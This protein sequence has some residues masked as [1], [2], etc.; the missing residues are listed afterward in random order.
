MSTIDP[1]RY[2]LFD[3]MAGGLFQG[4][5]KVFSSEERLG[6]FLIEFFRDDELEPLLAEL[7][8]IAAMEMSDQDWETYWWRS[9][10]QSVPRDAKASHRLLE[11]VM[12]AIST[13]ISGR[14]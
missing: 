2:K 8:D 3:R 9:P 4:T 10:A 6:V 12:G 5:A 11:A 14:A 13:A 7:R 1:T